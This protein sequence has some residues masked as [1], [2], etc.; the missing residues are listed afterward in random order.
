[1]DDPLPIPGLEP[2]KRCNRCLRWLPHS[3]F[4]RNRRRKDGIQ[5]RCRSCNI[6]TNKQWYRDHPE[7]RANRMDDY[8]RR[9][10]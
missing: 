8:A 6:E 3:A 2:L 9:R 4:H 7:A 1:M 5:N 10:R